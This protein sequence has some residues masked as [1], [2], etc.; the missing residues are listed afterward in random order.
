[1]SIKFSDTIQYFLSLLLLVSGML[2]NLLW[3]LDI[4]IL[5]YIENIETS[6]RLLL[7]NQRYFISPFLFW[8]QKWQKLNS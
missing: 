3:L 5:N 6:P 2:N 4:E 1:M 8:T 7:K